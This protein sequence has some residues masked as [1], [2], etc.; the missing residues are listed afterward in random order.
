MIT[1][2]LALRGSMIDKKALLRILILTILFTSAGTF[3]LWDY[4]RVDRDFSELKAL[5][6]DTR[7]RAIGNDKAFVVKFSGQEVVVSDKNTGLLIKALTVPTLAEVNYDIACFEKSREC[8]NLSR[9]RVVG[10]S[11]NNTIYPLHMDKEQNIMLDRKTEF[12]L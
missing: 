8:K 5:L 2:R 7:Y 12:N 6:Q 9:A 3:I 11:H 1:M 4:S 10:K